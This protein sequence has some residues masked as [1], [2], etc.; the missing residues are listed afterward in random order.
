[1]ILVFAE[2]HNHSFSDFCRVAREP[3]E[4]I[5]T[6]HY[7]KRVP[8][9]WML[10]MTRADITQHWFDYALLNLGGSRA[11]ALLCVYL[12]ELFQKGERLLER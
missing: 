4:L 12:K 7:H 10:D 3:E 2:R 6:L 5:K 1:M 8:T 9:G 11:A